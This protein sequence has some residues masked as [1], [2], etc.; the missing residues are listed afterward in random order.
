MTAT[1]KS[2]ATIAQEIAASRCP[3]SQTVRAVYRPQGDGEYAV[4]L[5]SGRWVTVTMDSVR[6]ARAREDA[7]VLAQQVSDLSTTALAQEVRQCALRGTFGTF[8][9]RQA[10]LLEAAERLEELA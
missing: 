5:D 9:Y 6:H 7:R 10:L 4:L 3:D 2:N 8:E 1:L